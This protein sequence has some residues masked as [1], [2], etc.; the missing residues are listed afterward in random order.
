[1]AQLWWMTSDWRGSKGSPLAKIDVSRGAGE[2]V[3]V[4][5]DAD[6]VD[7]LSQITT[8]GPESRADETQTPYRYNRE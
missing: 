1:V 8:R 7:G 3:A 6:G 2:L 5:A 4:Q